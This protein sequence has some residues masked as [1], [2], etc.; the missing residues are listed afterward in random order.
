MAFTASG[1][2]LSRRYCSERCS[3]RSEWK[4]YAE[5]AA[6]QARRRERE[7]DRYRTDLGYRLRR[8]QK[9]DRRRGNEIIPLAP[10]WLEQNG[11]C[12]LCRKQMHPMPIYLGQTRY[13]PFLATIEHRHPASR[14][15]KHT[16]ENVSLACSACNLQK[17]RQTVEEFTAA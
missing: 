14:G 17:G 10:I 13:D 15:G 11:K 7:L 5:D 2:G 9:S 12:Y 1:R 8:I 6:Y 16:R 3:R 4:R